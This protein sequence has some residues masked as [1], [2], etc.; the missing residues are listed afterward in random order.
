MTR[1]IKRTR[2]FYL[3]VFPL[4]AAL[5]SACGGQSNTR[6]LNIVFFL[7]DDLGWRDVGSFGSDFYDTPNIDRLAQDGI[8]FTHAYAASHVCSP[9]RAS[10]MT[11]KY[12]ARLHLT[13][14]LGGR[15]SYAFESLTSPDFLQQLPLEESTI[16]EAF[17]EHGYVTAHIGK[18]HLGEDPYG[19]LEQGFDMQVPDWNKGWP[20]A[21]YYA[22]FEL[23]GL[24][25]ESGQYL[26]DRLTDYA[27]DFISENQD[28]PFFLYMSHFAVHDPIHGRPDLVEKYR[29]KLASIDQ[30]NSP[31]FLL[32]GNPDDPQ[33]LTT[34]QLAS[35][36]DLPSYQ[37]YKVLPERAVKIKQHQDNIEFAAMVEAMD[38]SLGRLVE[39]IDQ[40]GLTNKTLIVFFS[41]NGG[42]SAANFGGASR[43]I[44]PGSLDAAY[45]TSNLPLRG[46]KGW[47][48]EGGIRVPMIVK[49]PKKF[50]E[51][52]RVVEEPIISTDFYPSLLEM[53]GLPASNDQE[54]D[55]V[56]FVPALNGE[57]FNRGPIFWHFP[58]YS[59]HGM[60]SPGGAVR[61][62]D[63]K[64]LEYFENN[65][66]Q[67]FNLREDIRER[68]DLAQTEPEI[69]DELRVLLRSWRADV[70]AQM[71]SRN[72]D[73][74]PGQY[75]HLGPP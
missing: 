54:L 14:W 1:K 2:R 19:P 56:S 43:V 41:D 58:Q 34:E 68:N 23:D 3:I 59:N 57:S 9:T 7:V 50:S 60:Q 45:S 63:Y 39:H 46:A 31:P 53:A 48:Y 55:G 4:L 65:T 49:W 6:P 13:E 67:L 73:Y 20:K 26:T 28:Q 44:D 71:P 17:K 35:F 74:D 51:P 12:P 25:D 42:M 24:K 70:N 69:R 8:K 47:L 10:I 11:G 15:R 21:G 33:P 40:L 16:A 36:I 27:V 30:P 66:V 62:G 64:L 52:S 75:P 18:W 72:S 38:E 29:Q 22:P 32:E 61:F 5:L 37:D